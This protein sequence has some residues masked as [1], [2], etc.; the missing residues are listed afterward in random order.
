MIDCGKEMSPMAP[1]QAQKAER[2][3]ALH[4]R[5]GAFVIPNPWDA[6][7]ARILASLGFEALTT[8][9]GG[10][11]FSLGRRDGAG[12]VTREETFANARAIVDATDLPVAADLENGYG[13]APEMVAETI[14]LAGDAAGLVGA[15]IEDAT[16]DPA[17]PLYDFNHAVERVAA[18]AE[19]ARAFPFPFVLVG[20][21]ENFL[22]GRPDLDD[23]I[24]RLQ[25]FEAA[26]A[27]ALFAPGLTTPEQ[28]R[29]V[30]A[31]VSTPV[32]VIMGIKGGS[33]SVAELAALGV[34]RI[35]VG[36]ALSRAALGA[37]LRAAR[38]IRDRGTF[39]F[40]L[41]ALPYAEVNALMRQESGV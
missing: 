1:T 30:C 36:S 19:A 32:N 3:Q 38:E 12:A 6:G 39:A 18:A 27:G 7:T 17:R 23:T 34:R 37:F 9:S 8:T 11:A 13:H 31:S 22:H 14:R 16:G 21:A 2:F 35:S 10:L 33:L 41:D 5:P 25:A 26:G 40:A 20:R 28:I 4:A 29:Q 15:S 24:R